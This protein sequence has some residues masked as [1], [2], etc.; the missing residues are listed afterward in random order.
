M[1]EW[2]KK[3]R[4]SIAR[5]VGTWH[6]K[7]EIRYCKIKYNIVLDI[8]FYTA[9]HVAVVGL[10]A[11][12]FCLLLRTCSILQYVI[13]VE[14]YHN[15]EIFMLDVCCPY[16]V[17]E[18]VGSFTAILCT[19]FRALVELR[20]FVNYWTVLLW[21]KRSTHNRF[22]DI[23]EVVWSDNSFEFTQKIEFWI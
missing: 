6:I 14:W 16:T 15:A 23:Q 8:Y 10:C 17:H 7:Y 12:L 13:D 4:D 21:N 19:R 2:W 5:Y 22:P 11:V 18:Q 20:I 1:R 9:G 3:G